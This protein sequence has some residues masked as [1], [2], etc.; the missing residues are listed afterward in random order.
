VR[1]ARKRAPHA[2]VLLIAL[3]TA[4]S[5]CGSSSAATPCWKQVLNDWTAT[6]HVK[7]TYPIAC[8]DQA[9]KNMGP[10]LRY[11]SDAPDAILTAKREAQSKKVRRLQGL[12][13]SSSP[14]GGPSA[15]AGS[16]DGGNNNGGGPPQSPASQ[17]LNAGPTSAD[18]LP[19]PLLFIAGLAILLLAAGA[20][21][22]ANRHVQARRVSPDDPAA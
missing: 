11:Y 9:M 22:V 6:Q 14:N 13:G 19:L 12:G 1:L 17:L 4:L 21:G 20:V 16:G 5:A 3:A 18:S 8:Y 15:G 10:D 7:T 2:L